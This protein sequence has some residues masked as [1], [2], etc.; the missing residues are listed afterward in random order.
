MSGRSGR[1]SGDETR[2]ANLAMSRPEKK[3][4]PERGLLG[5]RDRE[6]EVGMGIGTGPWAEWEESD[7]IYSVIHSWMGLI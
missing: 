7:F 4:L 6:L 2:T 1:L 5:P 3:S